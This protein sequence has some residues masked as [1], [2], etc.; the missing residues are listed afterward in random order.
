MTLRK[1]SNVDLDHAVLVQR[2]AR[3]LEIGR[4]IPPATGIEK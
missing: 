4:R 1:I 2:E 3:V